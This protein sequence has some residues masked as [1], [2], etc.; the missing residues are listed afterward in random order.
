M[1]QSVNH[2]WQR[3]ENWLKMNLP[4]GIGGLNPPATEEEIAAVEEQLNIRFPEDVRSSYLRH[5]G[6]DIRSTWILWGWEWHSLDRILETWND[7]NEILEDGAIDDI[8]NDGDGQIFRKDWWHPQWIPLTSDSGGGNHHC[9]DLA[10]GP[11]GNV[12]QIITMW[13]DDSDRPLLANSFTE[14]LEQFA[15]ALETGEYAYSKE[16]DSILALDEI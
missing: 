6:Q 10:P 8:E 1:D 16:Y 2:I 4:S 12:G 7:W 11:K 13:H 5:N 15:H 9:L 3:I 14:F